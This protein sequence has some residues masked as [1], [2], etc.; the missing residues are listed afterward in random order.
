MNKSIFGYLF[1][2][3]VRYARAIE[4][5]SSEQV[6]TVTSVPMQS[7]VLPCKAVLPY[8]DPERVRIAEKR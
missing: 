6:Y 8:Q 3:G 2:I 7:V 1:F 5:S 4:H